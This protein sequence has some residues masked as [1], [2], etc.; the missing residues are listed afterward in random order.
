MTDQSSIRHPPT[1]NRQPK[2]ERPQR[3]ITCVT[4]SRAHAREHS[5][6]MKSQGLHPKTY[7]RSACAERLRETI[8]IVVN[9]IMPADAQS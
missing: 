4:F 7:K 1:A 2:D 5:L 9:D 6:Q 3:I 8:F